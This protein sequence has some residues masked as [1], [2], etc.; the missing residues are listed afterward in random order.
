MEHLQTSLSFATPRV[1]PPELTEIRPRFAPPELTYTNSLEPHRLWSLRT[2]FAAAS[3]FLSAS[4]GSLESVDVSVF[5]LGSWGRPQALPLSLTGGSA[6]PTDA[7]NAA[8]N[9]GGWLM[10]IE[11][12]PAATPWLA[13]SRVRP[14]GEQPVSQPASGPG[15]S[16][17]ANRAQST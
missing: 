13:R 3:A 1:A 17:R 6:V 8:V 10:L 14:G 16:F 15:K 4:S 11:R 7:P 12:A 2:R 9:V 5:E